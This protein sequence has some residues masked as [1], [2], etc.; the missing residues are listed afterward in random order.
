M[1][2]HIDD[3]LTPSTLDAHELGL[4]DI[5]ELRRALGAEAELT[6]TKQ[7][8]APNETIMCPQWY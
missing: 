8:A 1:T 3:T 6:A 5:E 2:H 4:A 7:S